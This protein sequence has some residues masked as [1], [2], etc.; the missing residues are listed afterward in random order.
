MT[1]MRFCVVFCRVAVVLLLTAALSFGAN[2]DSLREGKAEIK[3]AGPLAF[4]PD[5]ILFVG[6][7]VGASIVALDTGDRTPVRSAAKINIKD[8][9]LKVAAALGASPD[10]ILL[11]D[12]VVPRRNTFSRGSRK[13]DSASWREKPFF[14]S[15]DTT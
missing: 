5:G 13:S 2:L 14:M 12:A 6:D 15:C 4:G 10:Q 3:S 11:N 8:I 9:N 1:P 7:S